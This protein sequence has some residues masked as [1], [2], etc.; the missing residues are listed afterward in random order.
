LR[1][2]VG[3]LFRHVVDLAMEQARRGHKV[4]VVCDAASGDRLTDTR[5]GALAPHLALKVLRVP[6][7][8]DLGTRDSSAFGA[9]RAAAERHRIDVLHGHGAK[10]GA[11]ARLAAGSLRRRGNLVACCY[12]PHGGSLHY[13]PASLAGRI[14]MWLERRLAS[15]TN[16]LVFESAFSA[17]RYSAQVGD[18]VCPAYVVPNGL[19]PSE[20]ATVEPVPDAADF[21]FIGELRHLKGVDL[22][23]DALASISAVRPLRAVIVGAG[24]DAARLR[25]KSSLLGL[26]KMVTFKG[27]MPARA[28]FRLGRVLVVPSR[29]ESL[30]YIV[31]EAAAASV[32]LIATHVG[33]I[34]E[35]VAGSNT[36]LVP[37]N[38]ADALAAAMLTALADQSAARW[39]ARQ[40]QGLV[41]H[42][43]SITAM[44][45]GVLAAYTAALAPLR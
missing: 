38:D 4:G 3:G 31:L 41:R 14:Y 39:R 26:D 9:I 25:A 5:L 37:S 45:D 13:D 2:P 23:L 33:G 21:L 7:S 27:P 42:R 19:E 36:T 24:S 12:T 10:G 34:P 17:S 35:I 22:M 43:F 16:A 15:R 32:P 8:R 30:P 18:P 29:A 1:T 28:A 40:L 20:F 44:V 6:M 11:Y